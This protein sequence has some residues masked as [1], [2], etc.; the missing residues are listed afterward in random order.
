MKDDLI[1]IVI[2]ANSLSEDVLFDK[3]LFHQSIT[4]LGNILL[5]QHSLENLP[6]KSKPGRE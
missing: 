1:I 2:I 4:S 5:S 6:D 3:K